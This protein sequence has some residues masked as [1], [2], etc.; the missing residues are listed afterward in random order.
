[1]TAITASVPMF[2]ASATR[3]GDQIGRYGEREQTQPPPHV[4]ADREVAHTVGNGERLMK[5]ASFSDRLRHST[6]ARQQITSDGGSLA[7]SRRGVKFAGQSCTNSL[8]G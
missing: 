1:M 3:A 8:H 7:E 4:C 6:T 2:G 5:A